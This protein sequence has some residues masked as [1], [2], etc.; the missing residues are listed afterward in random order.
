MCWSSR[1]QTV[2]PLLASFVLARAAVAA[3]PPPVPPPPAKEGEPAPA[4]EAT[5]LVTEKPVPAPLSAPTAGWYSG[6][7]FLRDPDDNFRLYVQGRVHIDYTSFYGPGVGS[8]PPRTRSRTGSSSGASGS[9]W[10]ASFSSAG[11]GS[12]P[13]R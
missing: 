3:E 4:A 7:F 6:T 1:P 2:L 10:Q 8:L 11:S 9:K 5:E 13:P 12:S